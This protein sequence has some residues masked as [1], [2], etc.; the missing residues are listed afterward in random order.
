M[1]SQRKYVLDLL[2]DIGYLGV[3]P[4]D[5]P[6]IINFDIYKETSL[7]LE[8]KLEFHRIVGKL[9]Y[10]TITKPDI[11]FL[12][13]LVSQFMHSSKVRHYQAIFQILKYLE[14]DSGKGIIYQDHDHL[15]VYR[16]CDVDWAGSSLD[17]RSR[18]GYSIFVCGNLISWRTNDEPEKHDNEDSK[19]WEGESQFLLDSQQLAEGIAA[20]EEFLQSQSSYPEDGEKPS[21]KS[22]L[23]DYASIGAEDFKRDLEECQKLALGDDHSINE[24]DPAPEMRLS[25]LEFGSQDSFMGWAAIIR[26][27][28][29]T[30]L[31][32]NYLNTAHDSFVGALEVVNFWIEFQGMDIYNWEICLYE[33]YHCFTQYKMDDVETLGNVAAGHGK[34]HISAP[35]CLE[36]ARPKS[37]KPFSSSTL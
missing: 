3:K 11:S 2:S 23:S 36:A 22:C 4:V 19:W 32:V 5:S 35:T 34:P 28:W 21:N 17:R 10:L 8:K 29:H 27:F 14:K 37:Y 1:I 25:Q 16:Y 13:G 9:I 6:V 30:F 15:K 31:L 20:C 26:S 18:S 24:A 7:D 12:V 33:K